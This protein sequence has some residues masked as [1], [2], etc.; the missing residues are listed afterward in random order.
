VST[1]KILLI[2]G[3]GPRIDMGAVN[4]A[5][6]MTELEWNRELVALISAELTNLKIPNAIMHRVTE[7]V[8]PVRQ[9]NEA[10]PFCCAEFHLNSFNG[11]ASGTEIIYYPSSRRGRE[12]A[13]QLLA[14]AVR[15]LGLPD[16]GIKGP[17]GGNRGMALLRGTRCPA[18]IVESFFIDNDR[19]LKI[20]TERR[21]KLAKAYA[22]AFAAYRGASS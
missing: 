2:I 13:L 8:Q 9:V 10:D 19:D 7:R 22:D 21:A 5:S 3:H 6:G 1:N 16:R 11:K 12:L 4:E 20:G 17:Q 18:V 14:A 15:T